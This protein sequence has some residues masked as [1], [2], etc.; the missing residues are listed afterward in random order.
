M[1]DAEHFLASQDSLGEGPLWNEDEQALYW[2][3]I[4]GKRFHRLDT[5][6][7]QHTTFNVGIPVCVLGFR[8]QGSIVMVVR[9]GFAFWNA[10]EQKLEYIARP[11]EHLTDVRFN[12][13]AIDCAGRF[14]AGSMSTNGDMNSGTLYRLDPDGSLHVMATS[15]GTSNGIGWNLD[16][17]VMYHTDSPRRVIYAYDFDAAS[18]SIT[19]HRPFIQ[20]AD[21]LP[22]PDGL[23]VDSE[24]YIWSAHWDGACVVRYTPDGRVDRTLRVPALHSSAC[25]F[26]GPT[27]TDL[28]ITSAQEGL[29]L[30]QLAQY[31][32]SGDLFHYQSDVQGLPR[33]KFAG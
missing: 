26:G 4:M 27:L 21:E 18:G 12:D 3:D 29:T 31:P 25:C 11:L 1:I 28:Y 30:E 2:V 32:L 9:D 22:Q 24:G 14:W 17:T 5:A 10:Q 15:I 6:S 20:L 8:Q 13:G 19:N 33:H 23:A 7:G 16:N